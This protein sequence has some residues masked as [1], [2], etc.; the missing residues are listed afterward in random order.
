[1][2]RWNKFY[3]EDS[4]VLTA[5][6]TKCVNYAVEVFAEAKANRILDLGCGV[7]RDGIVLANSGFTVTGNDVSHQALKHYK[8]KTQDKTISF[9]MLQADAR[10]LPFSDNTF[11][12]IYC[13][14]LLHEFVGTTASADVVDV[15]SEITR[16]LKPE[17]ILVLA[18]LAGNPEDGLPHVRLFTEQMLDDATRSFTCTDKKLY[19]DIGCT[20][21]SDYKIWR[22][23]Y[24]ANRKNS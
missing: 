1:M 7:G 15:I 13:F 5:Q 8:N 21:S 19:N 20:G 16:L 12:G 4:R 11:D 6:H 17:S 10:L 23:A 14:G 2:S 9:S 3:K 24:K 22:G 18:V